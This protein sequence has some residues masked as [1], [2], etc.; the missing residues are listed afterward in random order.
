[1]CARS[2]QSCLTLCDPM[3]C[4]LTGSS[5]H[6][7]L[8]ARILEWV[9]V[10]SSRGSSPSRDW[11]WVSYLVHWQAGS[12]PLAPHG[13][14]YDTVLHI[15]F[16]FEC[17]CTIF[18]ASVPCSF[19][20]LFLFSCPLVNWSILFSSLLLIQSNEQYFFSPFGHATRDALWDPHTIAS[21][22]SHM[23]LAARD[24]SFCK[25]LNFC[26]IQNL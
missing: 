3:D 13:K 17:I 2:L 10:S 15:K 5:V 4:S 14:P 9:A 16:I 6:G 1:M 19:S 24:H 25:K 20:L 18:S 12:L 23:C 22:S 26:N 21:H 11:T 8:Q 7:T